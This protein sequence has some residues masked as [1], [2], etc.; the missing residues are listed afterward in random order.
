MTVQ[1]IIAE[2]VSVL[3]RRLPE[4]KCKIYLF[5]SQAKDA[6]GPASDI[7][8]GLYG[9][10]PLDDLTLLRLRDEVKAIPTLRKIEIVDLNKTDA[11]F[12]REVLSHAKLL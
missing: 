9:D 5:G 8:I 11:G 2:T 3:R 10:K 7:D 12:R 1:Q 6:A 4:G